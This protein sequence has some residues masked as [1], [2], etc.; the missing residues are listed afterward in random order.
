MLHFLSN[1]W[2]RGPL[3]TVI[4]C[5]GFC[6]GFILAILTQISSWVW[7]RFICQTWF[8]KMKSGHRIAQK[9]IWE[10]PM[11][12][13]TMETD[14]STSDWVHWFWINNSKIDFSFRKENRMNSMH[15]WWDKQLQFNFPYWQWNNYKQGHQSMNYIDWSPAFHNGSQK[16]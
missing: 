9:W 12:T 8:E 10:S 5:G 6:F 3:T 7:I 14:L 4:R 16:I 1:T 2:I 11:R 15:N 13:D